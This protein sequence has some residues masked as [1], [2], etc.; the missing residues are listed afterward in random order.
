MEELKPKKTVARRRRVMKAAN[1][2]EPTGP[3]G[4]SMPDEPTDPQCGHSDCTGGA[5]NVHYV[6]PTSHMRD[7]HIVHA[8]RGISHV[9]S[10]AI[11]TG[12]A[13]VITGTVAFSSVQAK[14]MT[15]PLSTDAGLVSE[16]R[17]LSMR[18]DR[19]EGQLKV[20]GETCTVTPKVTTEDT[21]E[22]DAMEQ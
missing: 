7:H 19:M 13:V 2:P 6:G 11:I 5:C 18:L 17:A 8:A 21:S 10:A 16:L 12:L 15:P 1:A 3:V 20:M 9:W 4:G 14:T 22:I